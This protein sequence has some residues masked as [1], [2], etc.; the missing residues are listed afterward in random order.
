MEKLCQGEFCTD[1]FDA[2]EWTDLLSVNIPTVC[3]VVNPK[4]YVQFQSL[5]EE[6]I[7]LAK[8][9]RANLLIDIDPNDLTAS[10]IFVGEEM[11][12]TLAKKNLLCRLTEAADELT[13]KRSADSGQNSPLDLEGLVQM[14]FWFDFYETIDWKNDE[15]E[16]Q[17]SADW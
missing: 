14:E 7:T 16:I 3:T 10:I 5:I 12:F 11:T 13:V 8:T 6:S 9:I 17:P 15:T 1:D 4:K 2:E